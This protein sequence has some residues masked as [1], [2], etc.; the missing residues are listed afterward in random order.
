[1]GMGKQS[2]A[3]A[4]FGAVVTLGVGVTVLFGQSTP[5]HATHVGEAVL[6]TLAAVLLVMALI[7]AVLAV[8]EKPRLFITEPITQVVRIPDAPEET[9]FRVAFL[10][11]YN[12]AVMGSTSAN[13]VHIRLIFSNTATGNVV[14]DLPARW[15]FT[16]Q[17]EG[18]ESG[19]LAPMANIPR[20]NLAHPLDVALRYP[21]DTQCHGITNR[22]RHIG[23]KHYPLGIGPVDVLVVVE[24]SNAKRVA[25]RYEVLWPGNGD[26]LNLSLKCP[27]HRLRRRPKPTPAL[28][29][30]YGTDYGGTGA[31]GPTAR[32]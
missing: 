11:V 30:A 18:P 19:Q 21:G 22:S 15:A 9:T 27:S 32:S 2:W 5:T 7:F 12:R 28:E 31:S 25:A 17:A 8:L 4:C 24:G 10:N 26:T 3:I 13:D 6:V 1:M 20:N 14:Q 23:W 29:T 16:S